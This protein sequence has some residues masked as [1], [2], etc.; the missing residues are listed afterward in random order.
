M[1]TLNDFFEH[2]YCINLPHRNDRWEEI[3]KEF[4]K[5]LLVVEKVEAIDGKKFFKPG[6]NRHAGAYGLVLTN[7]NI[8]EDAKAKGYKSI[9]ILEDDISFV[10]DM[11]E[12]FWNKIEHLPN[13]WNLLYLGGNNQFHAGKFE[14][15]TGDKSVQ[16]LKENYNT[17]NYELVRTRWTQS[18]YAVGY[19]G[20]IIE[21][22]LKRLKNYTEPIDVLLPQLQNQEIYKSFVFLPTLAK[23]IDGFSDISG[24]YVEYTKSPA[25]NF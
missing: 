12:K 16:I 10:D 9:L 13:D 1:K 8:F 22:F 18:S 19:N 17:F 11:S 21:D 15:I 14:M 5:H 3:S 2:I 20:N 4:A 23:H 7:I 24:L 6:L 25:N